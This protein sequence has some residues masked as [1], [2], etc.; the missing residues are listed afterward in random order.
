MIFVSVILPYYKKKR[1]IK[2][3]INSIINQSYKNFEIIIIDDENSKQSIKVLKEIKKISKKILVFKNKKN[4]GAGLSRNKAIKFAKGKF[5][6][7]CDGDDLWKKSKLS[8]QIDFMKKLNAD[9]SYTSYNIINDGGSIIK[10]FIA[11]SK[12]NYD[13]LLK[14][15]DIG[16]STVMI[17][18]K[19]F[20]NN[21]FK[22]PK[23]ITKE[24]YVLWLKLSINGV[25]M[26]G[27]KEKLTSWRK[28]EKSLSSNSLQKIFDGY[29]VYRYYLKFNIIKSFLYLIRLS[30]YSLNKR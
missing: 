28:A 6:A 21:N 12:M 27:L 25:K 24:D 14:S 7:F 8:K 4:L 1:F 15:C 11:D 9:F 2:K 5:I 16:L 13:K 29:K 20:K 10:S 18:S 23:I 22:F 3:T 30:F 26:F 17:N 19:I